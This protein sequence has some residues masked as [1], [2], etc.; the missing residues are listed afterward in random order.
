MARARLVEVCVEST[1]QS[2]LQTYDLIPELLGGQLLTD[3]LHFLAG[4]KD[5][6]TSQFGTLVSL[7]IS[8]LSLTWSFMAYKEAQ[9]K[10]AL[11]ITGKML[12]LGSN[13]FLIS[14]RLASLTFWNLSFG[15]GQFYPSIVLTVVHV[16]V[17]S[18]LH[19]KF[20]TA[21]DLLKVALSLAEN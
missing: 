12:L 13:L 7:L 17:I 10:G 19:A 8:V 5:L 2:L 16:F 6:G 20:S 21:S 11:Q 14:A 15:P 18:I 4:E 1:F 9:K 3:F